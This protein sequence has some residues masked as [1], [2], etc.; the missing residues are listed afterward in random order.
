MGL[1]N[2]ITIKNVSEYPKFAP[3]GKVLYW[4]KCWGLR[5]A[6]LN[7]LDPKNKQEYT[8]NIEPEDIPALIRA[9]KPFLSPDYWRENAESIWEYDEMFDTLVENIINL[10]HLKEFL[11]NNTNAIAEFYDSY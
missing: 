2:G 8:F 5:D 6:F 4:R 11:L 3:D 10:E 1:D 7:V 9:I